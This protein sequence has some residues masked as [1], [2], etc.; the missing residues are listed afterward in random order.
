MNQLIGADN[1]KKP[2]TNKYAIASIVLLTILLSSCNKFVNDKGIPSFVYIDKIDF[3]AGFA[4]GSDSAKIT[5][6][7]IY[8]DNDYR[9]TYEL[10][11]TFPILKSGAQNITIKP[12]VVLNG[13]AATRSI[14]PFMKNMDKVVNLIP[15]SI[16]KLTL[17][18]TYVSDAKFVW[19]SVGQEDFE[20]SGITV[21][22]INGSTTNIFKSQQDVFEGDYSGQIHLDDSHSYF[23]GT[24]VTDFDMPKNNLGTLMEIHCKNPGTILTM[25]V[26]FNLAGGTVSKEEY[27]F[28]NKGENWKKMYINL[29]ELMASY[30]N[31]KN[32]KVFFSASLPAGMS[33]TNIYLD[34]IKLIHF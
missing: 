22:S 14:N 7:W 21:D 2:M 24:S 25:G 11:A 27:L 28:V 32:F 10:P 3:Q 9:G 8:I 34:N 29:T 18:T 17:S 1:R 30:S 23:I 5:D 13:I 6:V 16:I 26:F 20:Q 33:Q 15:D 31:A 4:Q 12:G 19:N